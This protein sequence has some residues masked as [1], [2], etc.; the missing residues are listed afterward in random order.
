MGISPGI[1]QHLCNYI[2]VSIKGEPIFVENL[3]TWFLGFQC[4]PMTRLSVTGS[5]NYS[6]VSHF[7]EMRKN[8][9]QQL[10]CLLK[11]ISSRDCSFCFSMYIRADTRTSFSV[12]GAH[13][14]IGLWN[15][16]ECFCSATDTVKF[17]T[18]YTKHILCT[19][20]VAWDYHVVSNDN[21]Y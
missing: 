10:T 12:R 14:P 7:A 19:K 3:D 20:A 4:V 18:Y 13:C 9:D 6:S 21:F 17:S 16:R 5:V 2:L 8:S 11:Y 1:Y 15:T